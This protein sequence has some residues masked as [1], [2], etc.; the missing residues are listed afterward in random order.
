[1]TILVHWYYTCT[2]I[3]IMTCPYNLSLTLCS[4]Q[5]HAARIFAAPYLPVSKDVQVGVRAGSI[6]RLSMLFEREGIELRL[7]SHQRLYSFDIKGTTDGGAYL[8]P[9]F[10]IFA[11][12]VSSLKLDYCY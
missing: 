10:L 5:R 8:V 4:L 2:C 3:L 9:F 6:M 11:F 7:W 1:M 12:T